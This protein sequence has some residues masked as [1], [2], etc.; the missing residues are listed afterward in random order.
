M[1][2]SAEALETSSSKI[3]IKVDSSLAWTEKSMQ[4]PHKTE[5]DSATAIAAPAVEDKPVVERTSIPGGD[6]IVVTRSTEDDKV[7][8]GN[9]GDTV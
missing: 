6:S 9:A 3:D 4:K 5:R 8:K 1:T 2:F 7:K